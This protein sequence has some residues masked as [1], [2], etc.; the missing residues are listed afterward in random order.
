VAVGKSGGTGRVTRPVAAHSA[1]R[2]VGLRG[3]NYVL[4]ANGFAVKGPRIEQSLSMVDGRR[5]TIVRPGAAP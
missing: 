4:P 1:P 3:R 2:K 5:E